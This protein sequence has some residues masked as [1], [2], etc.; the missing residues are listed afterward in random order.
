FVVERSHC[1]H[2]GHQLAWYENIPVLSWLALRGRCRSCKA[3]ISVQ[4][5]LV[6]LLTALLCVLCVWNFGFGWQGF[7]ACL[8]TCFLTVLLGPLAG[9]VGLWTARPLLKAVTAKD[10]TAPGALKMAAVLGAGVGLAGARPVIL[11]AFLLA[12]VVGPLALA[13]KGRD[14]ST[15]V[16]AAPD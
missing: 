2:C 3:P 1:P 5:P 9:A 6:E 10:V 16:P 12:A 15:P 8:L 14:L 13:A 11:W 7:G 4:Y